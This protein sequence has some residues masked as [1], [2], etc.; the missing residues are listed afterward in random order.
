MGDMRTDRGFTLV[1]LMVVVLVV[2]ILVAIAIP[3]YNAS[4]AMALRRTCFANQRIIESTA[5]SWSSVHESDMTALAGV[6]TGGHPLV[7]EYI[8]R[9]PPVCPSAPPAADPMTVDVD[10]GA[11]TLDAFGNVAPCTH[12]SPVHGLYR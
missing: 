2:G 5:Q 11:F 8:F 7:G 9:Q 6:V 10:H 1:E 4:R 3:V 12:G